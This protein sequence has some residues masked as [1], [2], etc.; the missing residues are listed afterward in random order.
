MMV[1]PGGGMTSSTRP[2]ILAPRIT[3]MPRASI[4]ARFL[5]ESSG[6]GSA[7]SFDRVSGLGL[8]RAP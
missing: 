6:G 7:A 5:P 2:V 1:M 8:A 4:D 3:M